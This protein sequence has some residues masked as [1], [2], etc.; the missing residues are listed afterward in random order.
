MMEGEKKKGKDEEEEED[1]KRPEG[2]AEKRTKVKKEKEEDEE[3]EGWEDGAAVLPTELS[4]TIS[5]ISVPPSIANISV[6]TVSTAALPSLTLSVAPST[7]K[8]THPPSTIQQCLPSPTETK[9][10]TEGAAVKKKQ[11]ISAPKG[12]GKGATG[13]TQTS[14]APQIPGKP[15]SAPVLPQF[16]QTLDPKFIYGGAGILEKEREKDWRRNLF[17]GIG[18]GRRKEASGSTAS[19][20]STLSSSTPKGK[21]PSRGTHLHLCRK[22]V[23]VWTT[24]K[25]EM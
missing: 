10:S 8:Q 23:K 14:E 12:A 15:Q 19:A 5:T 9:T 21:S 24:V 7:L 18:K 11:T 1:Q 13:K 2:G 20:S 16:M 6:T 25:F 3:Q 22:P 4:T 17:G